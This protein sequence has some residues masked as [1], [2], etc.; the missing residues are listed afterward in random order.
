MAT[1][2][3]S[4]KIISRKKGQN[5]VASAAYRS[6]E[7]LTDAKTGDVKDYERRAQGVAFKGIFAPPDAPEWAHDRQQLWNEVERVERRKDAQLVREF[8]ISLPHEMTGQQRQWLV[9]DFVREQFLRRGYVA[10]VAIHT[11]GKGSDARNHHAHVMVAMRAID[12]DGFAPTKDRSLNRVAQLEEWREKWADLANRHL[13]RHGY[14]ARIDH[15]SLEEQGITP[16]A[17]AP[18]KYEGA[19]VTAM[20]ARGEITDRAAENDAIRAR[21]AL[22]LVREPVPEN[23]ILLSAVPKEAE[24]V[25]VEWQA[26]YEATTLRFS[27]QGVVI[28][29]AGAT[30]I[31]FADMAADERKPHRPAH[32]PAPIERSHVA[33]P[34]ALDVANAGAVPATDFLSKEPASWITVE[35]EPISSRQTA[36]MAELRFSGPPLPDREASPAP[37]IA[38][39]AITET[40]HP[41]KVEPTGAQRGDELDDEPLSLAWMYA[42]DDRP[43]ELQLI[44]GSGK[45]ELLT[46]KGVEADVLNSAVSEPSHEAAPEPVSIEEK[47]PRRDALDAGAGALLSV[48]GKVAEAISDL[49]SGQE[50]L[51]PRAQER[52]AQRDAER[53]EARDAQQETAQAEKAVERVNIQQAAQQERQ[54]TDAELWGDWIR[55]RYA[56]R[57]EREHEG[58][59]E[60]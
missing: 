29:R 17:H 42:L 49:F 53:T 35:A 11:P 45:D 14:T 4:T 9:T 25:K 23:A 5:A 37:G 40:A 24:P 56:T 59:R 30:E 27:E 13:E 57:H 20:R 26:A 51:S 2:H 28:D 38:T 12:A 39:P 36:S 32:E 22:D 48:A 54:K 8:E 50:T 41:E 6:G 16:G 21:N 1:Y 31:R 15:R 43:A 58:G 60:L 18:E 44:Q 19:A 34:A 33:A 3:L 7:K 46:P 10:D 47:A 55:A 52:L